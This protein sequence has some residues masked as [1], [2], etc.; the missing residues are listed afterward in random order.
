MPR[1]SALAADRGKIH[2]LQK[3]D[4]RLRRW[5]V[6]YRSRERACVLRP[7]PIHFRRVCSWHPACSDY[8]PGVRLRKAIPR[9]VGMMLAAIL[10]ASR[11]PRAS[12]GEPQPPVEVSSVT[13]RVLAAQPGDSLLLVVGDRITTARIDRTGIFSRNVSLRLSGTHLRGQ[14]GGQRAQLELANGRINGTI[15]SSE[16]SLQVSRVDGN[17]KISGRFGARSISQ[18]LSPG[19]IIAEIGPCRY[20][21]KYQHSE[22]S[23]QVSCG[24]QPEAVHLRVPAALVARG[25]T[26]FAALFTSLLAR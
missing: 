9:W 13:D 26:E 24:G 22:Y 6:F 11:T 4:G 10:I 1:A 12:A 25:D 8:R 14:V 2:A 16:V 23:G 20:A 5:K 3:P 19:A 21:L 17:L 18:D 15:A 7:V